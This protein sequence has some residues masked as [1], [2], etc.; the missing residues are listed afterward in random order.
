MKHPGPSKLLIHAAAVVIALFFLAVLPILTHFDLSGG[1]NDADAVSSASLELPDQPSGSFVVLIN[2]SLHRDT[3]DDWTCFFRGDDLPVIFED[4]QCIV[5]EGDASGRQ[6]AERFMA[7]LP[8]NQM[9]LR[10]EDPTLLVSKAEA[11]DIDVAVFS[12]EMADLLQLAE[13]SAL[14]DVVTVSVQGG[15]D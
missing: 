7:Q 2:S 3:L 11:G 13:P 12:R 4:I 6:L 8:E 5:A 10:A 9:V 14:N 1:Q 15:A